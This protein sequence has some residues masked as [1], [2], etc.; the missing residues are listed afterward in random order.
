MRVL[1]TG[2]REVVGSRLVLT[3]PERD[4]GAEHPIGAGISEVAAPNAAVRPVPARREF[5]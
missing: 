4:H 2:A 3:L 1:V 5:V